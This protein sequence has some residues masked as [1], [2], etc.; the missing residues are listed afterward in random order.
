[1]H[2][3]SDPE[4]L[5]VRLAASQGLGIRLCA[6]S[7][8]SKH[9][10]D[11]SLTLDQ[12]NSHSSFPI[13]AHDTG[14]LSSSNLAQQ[15]PA[16]LAM[17]AGPTL[18]SSKG[19]QGLL[20]AETGGTMLLLDIH[21]RSGFKR[22]P[23]IVPGS[24]TPGGSTLPRHSKVITSSRSESTKTSAAVAGLSLR[25]RHASQPPGLGSSSS[26]M[27]MSALL[28][29]ATRSTESTDE[30]RFAIRS[31]IADSSCGSK[32]SVDIFPEGNVFVQGGRMS[33]VVEIQVPQAKLPGGAPIIALAD[34]KIRILGFEAIPGCDYRHLFYNFSSSLSTA[35]ACS[36]QSASLP[37]AP[38]FRDARVGIHRL[39]FD[40]KIPINDVGGRPKGVLATRS[41]ISI[42]YIAGVSVK[43][44]DARMVNP[45]KPSAIHV[46]RD[47][48]VWPH[49]DPGLALAPSPQPITVSTAK[50][51]F[52]GGSGKLYLT[53]NL[54]RHTW[55]AGQKCFVDVRIFN[56]TQK[57]VKSLTLILL[58]TITI[59]RPKATLDRSTCGIDQ[60]YGDSDACQTSSNTKRIAQSLLEMGKRRIAGH[61]T[62]KGWWL[63]VEAGREANFN[64]SILVPPDALSIVCDRLLE[65][66]YTLRVSAGFGGFS[67]D[68]L[69]DM[70]IRIVNFISID[71]PPNLEFKGS[72]TLRHQS[73][74]PK[75][76]SADNLPNP[77]T[78]RPGYMLVPPYD[79]DRSA[80]QIA[81]EPLAPLNSLISNGIVG[82]CP[83]DGDSPEIQKTITED[84]Q[85]AATESAAPSHTTEM[86]CESDD[87]LDFLVASADH[88]TS[89]TCRHDRNH[90]LASLDSCHD[91]RSILYP[92]RPQVQPRDKCEAHDDAMMPANEKAY[93]SEAATGNIV[94]SKQSL[95]API[96]RPSAFDSGSAGR[97]LD[98]ME[99]PVTTNS[100]ILL[101]THKSSAQ[102]NTFRSSAADY[103]PEFDIKTRP[104][105]RPAH[106]SSTTAASDLRA[107]N[108]TRSKVSSVRARIAELEQ[109]SRN[110]VST[111]TPL[112]S[113]SVFRVHDKHTALS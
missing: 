93:Q 83:P 101:R 30:R 43:Y 64:H 4:Q 84:V 6:Y 47:C 16:P 81:A 38:G 79:H 113:G 86:N 63:G 99:D 106:D 58:R 19:M 61:V 9:H 104:V 42:Q 74:L 24:L 100:T 29:N 92:S 72:S 17:L 82:D 13:Q 55:I 96:K 5:P 56:D 52:L 77:V 49:V 90:S 12:P 89:T 105:T 76:N 75:S 31:D 28:G 36:G 80:Q 59:Y 10:D 68:V 111:P 78:P 67:S 34:A 46:Y 18:R 33:G 14:P 102:N 39:R 94:P 62:A 53:A 103:L 20:E 37:D 109:R 45:D 71:P 66:T 2:D 7:D 98:V 1:M 8:T 35:S 88:D 3:Q 65:V 22:G 60:T 25:S 27:E 57:T 11:C 32:L 110:S 70:P 15:P 44:K 95:A 41:G 50:S 21:S 40:I 48:E 107:Y 23:S 87:E 54:R 108:A 91:A 97:I 26:E 85:P 69:A 73:L 112:Q 51:V